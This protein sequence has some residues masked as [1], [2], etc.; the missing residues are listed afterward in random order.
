MSIKEIKLR[1]AA[2][3]KA[4]LYLKNIGIST[5][6]M[7]DRGVIILFAENKYNIILNNSEPEVYYHNWILKK[8][9]PGNWE[10]CKKIIHPPKKKGKLVSFKRDYQDFLQSSYW[11]EISKKVKKRDNNC[12]TICGSSSYLNVHHK[13]YSHHFSEHNHLGDLITLCRNCHRKI[14]KL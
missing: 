12:C 2:T 6:Y 1:I 13:T 5:L 10:V 11:K 8:F 4:K 3:N 14:H 7:S 9:T